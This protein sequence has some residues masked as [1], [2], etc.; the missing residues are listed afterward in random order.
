MPHATRRLDEESF[1][2]LFKRWKKAVEKSNIIQEYRN[3]EFYEKPSIVRKRK[4]AA[5]VKRQQRRLEDQDKHGHKRSF[6]QKKEKQKK[7][8]M[9]ELK[10][11]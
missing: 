8:L 3:R 5:A 11:S 6:H 1:E 4:K 7:E 2:S 9:D 10:F